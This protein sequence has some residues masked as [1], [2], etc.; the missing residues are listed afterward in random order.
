MG[1][2]VGF[3]CFQ[4]SSPYPSALQINPPRSDTKHW[5]VVVLLH[6]NVWPFPAIL[7]HGL[8]GPSPHLRGSHLPKIPVWSLLTHCAHRPYFWLQIRPIIRIF[9]NSWYSRNFQIL[10]NT[11]RPR[12]FP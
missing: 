11:F 7:P 8:L 4:T 10:R 1:R 3:H 2:N 6:R 5:T 9:H 12:T